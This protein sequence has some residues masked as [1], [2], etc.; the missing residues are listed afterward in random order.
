MMRDSSKLDLFDGFVGKPVSKDA[1]LSLLSRFLRYRPD[2]EAK[3][4][5][6]HGKLLWDETTL[7]QLAA[8]SPVVWQRIET[9]FIKAM[10]SNS[11]P[12]IEAFSAA[13]R[14]MLEKQKIETLEAYTVQLD[15]ALEAFD[16]TRMEQLLEQFK[17]LRHRLHNSG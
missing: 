8:L 11:I 2:R 3:R 14:Q 7:S 5:K 9:A 15:A 16:I 12:D 1:L 17:Q 6:V 10:Q 4:K 13:V